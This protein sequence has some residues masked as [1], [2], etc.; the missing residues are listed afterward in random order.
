[1]GRVLGR[2]RSIEVGRYLHKGERGTFI[3]EGS[4]G[5]CVGGEVG[6][7]SGLC[8]VIYM[9]R[10]VTSMGVGISQGSVVFL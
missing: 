8:E 4:E 5:F 2:V 3:N 1:M 6:V 9:W 10:W 7:E